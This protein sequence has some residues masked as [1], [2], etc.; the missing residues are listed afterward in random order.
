MMG[1]QEESVT[2]RVVR[3]KLICECGGE[4]L[5]TGESLLSYPAKYPHVCSKCGH[6]E[7]K[8]RRYPRIDYEELPPPC[9]RCYG[10]GWVTVYTCGGE[11]EFQ[12]CAAS[13]EPC[14]ECQGGPQE[15][16]RSSDAE[17]A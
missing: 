3:V 9:K 17:K 2:V 15:A 10:L 6:T 1:S 16:Q 11:G 5:P 7:K 8:T 14:P 4:M 13:N 12:T